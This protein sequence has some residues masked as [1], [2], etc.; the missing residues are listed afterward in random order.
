M[1]RNN[2]FHRRVYIILLI[3]LAAALP[4]SIFAT[5]VIQFLLALNWLIEGDFAAKRK[6]I[7]SNKS[8]LIFSLFYLAHLVGM[9]WSSDFQYGLQDLKIKLPLI[10][11]PFLIVSSEELVLK[12]IR[13]ILT[14]F[15]GGSLI[16]SIATILALLNVIP[17]DISDYR[18]ASL[19]ISHIRFSL[20]IV[21]S[22]MFSA[23]FLMRKG[24]VS[25]RYLKLFFLLSLLW[26]PVFLVILR[27]LSGIVI[28]LFLIFFISLYLVSTIPDRA[29]RFMLTVFIVFI[30]LFGIIYIGSSINR[31]YTVEEIHPEELDSLTIQ[32]NRYIH[33]LENGETENGNYVWI[34]VC[35]EELE[36][37]WANLSNYEY[38]GKAEN[39]DFLRFT[40]IRYL[41][42]K[43]LRKDSVGLHQ[44][45]PVDI[46]AIES[47]IAN[48]IYLNRFALYPRIYE[49]IWEFD[50]YRLGSSPNDKSL[51]QRYFY[52]KAGI[53][54]A[55]QNLLFGVGTGDVRQ[56]FEKYYDES[57][58][59]LRMER[60]RRAHN[61][62]LTLAI[63]LGIPGLI[64]CMLAFTLPVF[65]NKR[66]YS[67]MAIVFLI[68]MA[69]SMLDEDTLENTPGAV[70]FGL[71][72][73]LFILGPEWKWRRGNKES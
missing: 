32:G 26:L 3:L 67:Y 38:M 62:Y 24:E 27:S 20:M 35:P 22:I 45:T 39:G 65:I 40:I 17:V 64:L 70:M 30:P 48:H 29:G 31:F 10:V 8:F 5:S 36:K 33:N 68:T 9:I 60:R 25:N 21:L 15:V 56:S 16:A 57:D 49:V 51:I 58:S 63:A 44:L 37:E 28:I 11:I 50:R 12:E 72:Y 19:F 73:A 23:Y 13:Y 46:E 53:H 6:R 14:S 2:Y 66:W 34:Y 71:F 52:L 69:L 61:Q 4:L 54:I 42:S 1:I 59:P 47:G 7:S 43:G 18:N 55:S 41:T